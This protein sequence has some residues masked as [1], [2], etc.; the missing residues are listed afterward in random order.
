MSTATLATPA[1]GARS[2]LGRLREYLLPLAAISVIFVMLV[3]LP[4]AGL[5]LLLALSMA[6][7]MVVFLTAV[8]IRRAVELSVFPT[9][10][11]LLTL[12]RLALNIASSRRILLHGSEGT[13]AAGKVIEA[14]GQFVVGGNYVVGFVLFLALIAIQF[15]VVSHGAVR[16]AEVTARFTLDALP[17]KQ[18]AIDADMNAGL[19]DE[20]EARKRRQAVAREAEFYGAMDG[21][22]RFNQRDS[23]ATIL[24]TA[25]NIIAG[26]LI[27]TLQ[28][29]IALGEAVR[30]YTILTVG[31]GLVTMI[32]SLLVSVAGGITL[33]RANSS[34]LLGGEIRQQLLARPGTLYLASFVCGAL[35]LIPGLPKIAFLLVAGALF[36]VGRHME[37]TA[38]TAPSPAL[39]AGDKKKGEAAPAA[40][41]ASLMRLEDLTLEI[42][43]Q[44]IPL[45]DERQGGQL[46][47]RVRT[48]RRHL[49]TEMGF[50]IP[51]VHI[52]DNL[53]L[54]PREYLFSLRGIEIGRWQ[55]EGTQLLAVSG[56][57]NRR[58]L[59]G[60]EAREPAFGVPAVWIAAELEEQAIAAGYSVVDA[61][62]VI[63]THLGELI[64]RHAG[65]LLGR[66]EIKRLM[67]ALNESH[68]KLIEELVPK[69]LTLGE[70]A[71]VLEQ[72]L[73]ERVSIRDLGKILEAL[74]ETA[75]VNKSL[76]ALVEASRQ[77]LGRRLIQPLLD[78]E[79]QLP[80]LLLDPALEEEILAS[81]GGE[82]SQRLLAAGGVPA[83]PVLRRLA[84]SLRRLIG[85]STSAALP[86]LLCPSP[87]RYT[88]KRWLEPVVP[89]LAVVAAAE[90]P[91]EVRLRPVGTVR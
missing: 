66:A 89:R 46:L 26:L 60:R 50:L 63:T 55:T 77:A 6:A 7:S 19:I 69:L 42:G 39:A 47:N 36:W 57:P 44:L 24:I 29:G 33:T 75:P 58:P 82:T 70:A 34:A 72:L 87:A 31:D 52:S 37:K 86:V 68:P 4:A 27:G 30:T 40:E 85:A 20:A 62:T 76:I 67:D 41:L 18:M 8:Q 64:R 59:P 79:G 16:T 10:L 21:A 1:A 35:C 81:L 17:G 61:V 71:R 74:L 45:V 32:P 88:V 9:L 43:F 23:L 3:P 49:S 56:D 54:R 73:R 53:R 5:D 84:D 38:V 25:I 15:L 83:T 80:V 11:L 91:P 2:F 90:I 51:P 13:G 14:F 12:F 22:A 78:A 48:L 28:Q 65:E